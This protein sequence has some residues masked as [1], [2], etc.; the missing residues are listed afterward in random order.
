MA[1]YFDLL[2]PTGEPLGI[3]K[4]RNAVHRDGDWHPSVHI[5]VIQGDRVLLQR[6]KW[7]KESFPGKLDLACTGH[8][9]TGEDYLTAARRELQEE[10]NLTAGADDLRYLFTQ[11][12]EVD[13]DF[14]HGRF[15]S[16]EHCRVYL[17]NPAV[18][19]TTLRYQAEEIDE[20]VWVDRH[21]DITGAD[22]CLL[23]AEW[24]KAMGLVFGE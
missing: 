21:T 6:R 9:D 3:T 15:V 14:G 23:P 17:L 24:N 2:S 8:V 16:N 12:L 20:L 10:L 4:E 5:F 22:Y 19:L 1:E 7:D 18:P 11:K 13:A